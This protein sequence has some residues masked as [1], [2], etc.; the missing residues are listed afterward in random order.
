LKNINCSI[1][2]I[3]DE[4]LIGQTIDTNS[5]WI[6][7]QLNPIGIKVRRRVAVGDDKEDVLEALRQE[8]VQSD[9]IILTGGLGP[10]NDDITKD[11]LCTY[12]N[13]ELVMD[14]KTLDYVTAYFEKRNRPMLAV[15]KNQALVPANCEPLFN[16]VGTA[17]GLLFEPDNKF[18]V[19]LPGVPFEMQ[20]LISKHIIHKLK[21][22]YQTPSFMHRTLVTSGEGES[23]IAN[24]LIDFE[25]SL[26][27]NI[28]LAYLPKL[29]IVK[30]RLTGNDISD[31]LLNSYFNELKRRLK[32]I[33]VI[34]KDMELEAAIAEILMAKNNTLALAESCTGGYIASLF[35]AI[36]GASNFFNG[37]AVTYANESKVNLLGVTTI[38]N[39]EETAVCESVAMEMAI[40]TREKFKAD[41]G[42]GIVG[43]LEQKDH[44]NEIWV[45]VADKN[46]C[47]TKTFTVPYDRQKNTVLA[48]NTALNFLR[49]FIANEL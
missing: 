44:Q 3:G 6:A 45:A 22:K 2:T 38:P 32:S 15:N 20:Y 47:K 25:A 26:P 34:D 10:T 23:F 46:I 11:I 36:K 40:A 7:Q 9:I 31:D 21:D 33:T 37:S 42:L 13:T 1:I 14:Q 4:L 27:E 30:L 19:A 24:K 17:P 8:L 12:F 39:M 18:I 29:G 28:K 48:S 43:Y 16:A 35:T 41:Y 5:A 49:K